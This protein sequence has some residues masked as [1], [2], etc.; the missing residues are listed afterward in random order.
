MNPARPPAGAGAPPGATPHHQPSPGATLGFV[1]ICPG[2]HEAA[3]GYPC[4]A[5]TGA[6]LARALVQ[7]HA[8]SP[9][10]FPSACRS[11][12]V[13]TNAWQRVE[14]PA[15]TGRSVPTVD[16]VLASANLRRLAAELAGLQRVVACGA[17]AH[18][19]LRALQAA[20][21]L[22]ATATVAYERHLSQ[23][24][25]NMIAGGS[26]TPSRLGLW[27]AAVLAQLG[28]PVESAVAGATA[29]A[30]VP[31]TASPGS[32]PGVCAQTRERAIF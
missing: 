21:A 8:A 4:A 5:G 17:Q 10:L 11:K 22:P 14:Y 20:G 24:A 23:R 25:V 1:F 28:R 16:E 30:A 3:R 2:R 31:V 18:A 27:C 13:V 9:A 32:A 26:D 19:A 29:E 6:N 7:L 15:L 12:Y